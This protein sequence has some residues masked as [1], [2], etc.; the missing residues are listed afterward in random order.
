LAAWKTLLITLLVLAAALAPVLVFGG[1]VLFLK[2]WWLLPIIGV[3]L[4]GLKMLL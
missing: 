3:L 2:Y 4:F 1:L